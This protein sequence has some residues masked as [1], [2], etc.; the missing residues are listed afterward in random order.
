MGYLARMLTTFL[1][2]LESCHARPGAH[3]QTQ[4]DLADVE[5]LV[6]NQIWVYQSCLV[7]PKYILVC[8]PLFVWVSP[9]LHGLTLQ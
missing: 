5:S 4:F 3:G 8:G 7:S 6:L 9:R 2:P 1:N